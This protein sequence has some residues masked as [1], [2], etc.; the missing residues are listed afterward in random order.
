MD[1]LFLRL[2][3]LLNESLSA[4]IAIISGSFFLYS[5]VKDINNRVARAFSAL[6]FF[7]TVTYIGDLGVSFAGGSM[8]AAEVWLRFQWLG[9][10]F[11]PAAY[12]HLSDAILAMTGLVSRGRRRWGVR[13]LYVA[14]MAF[15]VIVQ[16]TDW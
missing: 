2:G 16:M 13:F 3:P 7:V 10:A 14:A 15:F 1:A 4:A 11:A 8:R 12:V 9:I 5:L 6:L